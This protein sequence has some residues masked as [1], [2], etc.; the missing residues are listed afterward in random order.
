[1]QA[2]VQVPALTRRRRRQ[3][4]AGQLCGHE[5]SGSQLSMAS[6]APLPQTMPQSLSLVVVQ[7]DG[8]QPS[9]DLQTVSKPASAQTAVHSRR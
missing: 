5:A 7:P 1:M 3:P 6:M 9:F 8:Q 4:W 2:A